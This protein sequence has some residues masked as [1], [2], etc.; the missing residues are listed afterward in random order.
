MNCL[1]KIYLVCIINIF[2]FSSLYADNTYFIDFAKVLNQSN[3]GSAAQ[4]TLKKKFESENKKF[5]NQE[6]DLKNLEKDLISQKKIL[7][8]EDYQKKLED[9]RKKVSELQINKQNSLNSIAKSRINAKQELL[10]VINPIIKQYMEQN[11][12][13]IIIEKQS[14]VLGDA[15]LEITDQIIKL[16]NQEVKS[17]KVN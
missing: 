13:R 16:V 8:N 1:K 14:V 5:I 15:T 3:A 10:K 17:I 11:N 4:E 7:S 12:I 9:L 2:L 6:N